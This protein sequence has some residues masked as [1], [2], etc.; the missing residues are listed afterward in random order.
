MMP[1]PETLTA[2]A[3]PSDSDRNAAQ[4]VYVLYALSCVFGI[5]MI[6]GAFIAYLKRDSAPGTWLESHFRWQLRTFWFS[7]LWFVAGVLL[8]FV[9][10]GFP[11]L[12]ALWLWDLYR[13]IKGWTRL[14]DARP[15]D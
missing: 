4:A 11:V 15:V 6:P 12:A 2:N 10:I 1:A 14:N 9:V 3:A 7:L 5:T 13:V 8:C